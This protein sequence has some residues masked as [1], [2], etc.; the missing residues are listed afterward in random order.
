MVCGTLCAH[1]MD[2]CKCSLALQPRLAMPCNIGWYL[3]VV[4]LQHTYVHLTLQK[5]C[6]PS[7]LIY[8]S[9]VS[10]VRVL[11]SESHVQ[12]LRLRDVTF[13]DLFLSFVTI[14]DIGLA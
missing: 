12:I 3:V 4:S 1:T 9:L 11:F 8:G 14:L 13:S 10:H 2:C 7:L 5:L 6:Q